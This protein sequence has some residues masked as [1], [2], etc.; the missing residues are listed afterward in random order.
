[1]P[2]VMHPLADIIQNLFESQSCIFRDKIKLWKI[3]VS[4]ENSEQLSRISLLESSQ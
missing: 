4:W 2:V 1:M 3:N